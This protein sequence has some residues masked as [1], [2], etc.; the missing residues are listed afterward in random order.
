VRALRL[1]HHS[2]LTNWIQTGNPLPVFLQ[3]SR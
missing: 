1:A 2:Q 3:Q